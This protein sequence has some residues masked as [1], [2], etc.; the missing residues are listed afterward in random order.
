MEGNSV[1]FKEKCFISRES[2]K[3]GLKSWGKSRK[4]LAKG[5]SKE[6]GMGSYVNFPKGKTLVWRRYDI[7]RRGIAKT[8]WRAK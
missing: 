3:K 5:G 2:W 6:K 4:L 1:E 7:T 8:S